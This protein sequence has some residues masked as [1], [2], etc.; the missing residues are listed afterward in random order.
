M[1][2]YKVHKFEIYTATAHKNDTEF[3]KNMYTS[4][5]GKDIVKAI[6]RKYT[7]LKTLI[8]VL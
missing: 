3:F 6:Y 2:K 7:I 5:F 4:I 8:F 1:R